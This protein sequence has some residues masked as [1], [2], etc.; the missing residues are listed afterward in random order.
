MVSGS[1][2][3]MFDFTNRCEY[4]WRQPVIPEN[5]TLRTAV[6]AFVP[7]YATLTVEYLGIKLYEKVK[8][9]LMLL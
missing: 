9:V 7:I 4:I 2:R 1:D 5:N 3:F 6:G 8:E